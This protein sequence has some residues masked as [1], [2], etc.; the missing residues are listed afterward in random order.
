MQYE[1]KQ[2]IIPPRRQ[3]YQALIAR[4]GD[5]PATRYQEGTVGI[6][7]TENFH[8]RPQWDSARELYDPAFS[9]LRLIDAEGFVD[10]RQYYYA[11]YVTARTT[12]HEEFGKAL[13]YIDERDL[14]SRLPEAWAIAVRE[15]IVPL[16]HAESGAQLITVNGAR[17]AWGTPLAQCLS[18]AAFDRVGLA[19]MLSRIGIS[20]SAGTADALIEAKGRWTGEEHFQPMRKLTEELMAEVDWAVGVIG[21]D[22]VD[23][24]VYPVLYR[25]LDDAAVLG[26]AGAYSLV[27]QHFSAWF[28][29]QRKWLDALYRA[30]TTDPEHGEANRAEL[31]RI[32]AHLLPTAT[33]ATQALLTRID[34][35]LGSDAG[36]A[37]AG[38]AAAEAVTAEFAALGVSTGGER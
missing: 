20:V 4:N 13:S 2:N 3:T 8:Y 14:F 7:P 9:A 15:L 31:G 26:G 22:L 17:F 23:R 21:Q 34:A 25:H 19:Q 27:T 36:A 11:P 38:R 16:R 1:L 30:W 24:I 33:A 28:T 5:V 37:A 10:P 12:L 32:V 35:V 6:Q 18:Y 29:D